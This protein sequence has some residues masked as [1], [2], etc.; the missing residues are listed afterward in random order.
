MEQRWDPRQS[1]ACPASSTACPE[2]LPLGAG[3]REFVS[4]LCN[5]STELQTQKLRTGTETT[6]AWS[7]TPLLYLPGL[8]LENN[9]L[10]CSF[11]LF[12]LCTFSLQLLVSN[13]RLTMAILNLLILTLV[14][15]L[16]DYPSLL[17][18]FCAS[19]MP[20]SLVAIS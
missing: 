15:V 1:P 9:F 6:E 16:M 8:P 13:H 7:W 20:G 17:C 2:T 5:F 19:T 4:Y 18:P 10:F 12:K 14:L 3:R 11:M